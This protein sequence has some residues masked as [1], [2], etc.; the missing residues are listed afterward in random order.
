MAQP[1]ENTK[2][3][4]VRLPASIFEGLGDWA[5]EEGRK[6]GNLAAHQLEQAVRIKYPGR[7][8]PEIQRRER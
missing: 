7:F 5:E 3:I 1:A 8:P 6:V 4:T 2:Q